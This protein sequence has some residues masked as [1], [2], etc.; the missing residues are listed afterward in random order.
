LDSNVTQKRNGGVKNGS[1]INHET[2]N[3]ERILKCL[4]KQRPKK[5]EA[6]RVKVTLEEVDAKSQVVAEKGSGS[7]V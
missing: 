5:T 3:I 1:S 6:A 4:K 7:E 2:Q